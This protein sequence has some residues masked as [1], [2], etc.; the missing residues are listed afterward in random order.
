M[1]TSSCQ[2]CKV[3]FENDYAFTIHQ[4][5]IRTNDYSDEYGNSEWNIPP[6]IF[7][8]QASSAG[9]YPLNHIDTSFARKNDFLQ[10]GQDQNVTEISE[11][12]RPTFQEK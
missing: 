6:N 5:S 10:T 1:N 12:Y 3:M 7:E 8:S 2:V 11:K 9:E 4:C